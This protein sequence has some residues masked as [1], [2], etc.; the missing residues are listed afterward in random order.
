[1]SMPDIL[2]EIET[3][4][5]R[6]DALTDELDHVIGPMCQ[7]RAIEYLY[8]ITHI[9][10]DADRILVTYSAYEGDESFILSREEIYSSLGWKVRYG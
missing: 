3:L 5:D 7:A 10:A 6:L 9:E 8:C 1:M 4:T 2:D